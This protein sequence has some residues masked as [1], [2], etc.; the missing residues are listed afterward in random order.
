MRIKYIGRYD[1][2]HYENENRNYFISAK[3]KMDYIA[4]VLADSV[5]QVDIISLAWTNNQGGY[6][7]GREGQISNKIAYKIG[8]TFGL[9]FKKLEFLKM[10]FTWLWFILYMIK[11]TKK[12]ETVVVYHAMN[13]II[14]MLIVKK[15]KKLNMILEVEEIYQNIGEYSYFKKKLEYHMF[16]N[17]E[18]FI[19]SNDFLAKQINDYNKE[20]CIVYGNY[21][22]EEIIEEKLLKDDKIHIVYA[23]VIN[24]EKGSFLTV[25]AAKYLSEKYVIH[26][27]GYGDKRNIIELKKKIDAVNLVSDCKV[28][29]DG[30]LTGDK[31][32]QFLQS[33]HIG[34]VTQ[35][36]EE[37]YNSVS[38]PSKICSYLSNGLEVL[39]ANTNVI[40][41][42]KLSNY[43]YFYNE[44][45]PKCISEVIKSIEFH[46]R[47]EK[48]KILKELNKSLILILR[49]MIVE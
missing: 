38:F 20:Y 32:T 14:P 4:K 7:K 44:Q 35:T 18:K 46:E 29:Y 47:V 30:L 48:Q 36:V 42:S 11:N 28:T 1:I 19:F 21:T 40:R 26:I 3:N 13:I 24:K 33:C 49:D 27:I 43:L 2:F 12:N 17:A 10:I 37:K 31:Y 8:P 23:G 5:G 25:E 16:K 22:S 39:C 6:Y 15:I 45:D 41:Q 9:H 34:M